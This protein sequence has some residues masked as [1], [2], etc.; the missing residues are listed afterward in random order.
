[1]FLRQIGITV[2]PEPGFTRIEESTR[3]GS[4]V[5][6]DLQAAVRVRKRL[7]WLTAASATAC[8]RERNQRSEPFGK[9][10]PP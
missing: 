4:T 7:W 3:V 9:P 8:S 5:G 2:G 10:A 1:M 6:R